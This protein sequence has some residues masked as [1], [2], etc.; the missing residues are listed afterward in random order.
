MDPVNWTKSG[1]G[2][3]EARQGN[4]SLLVTNGFTGPAWAVSLD[5]GEVLR[6]GSASSLQGAML[7]A[8]HAAQALSRELLP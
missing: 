4:I 1:D 3:Y 2:S 7:K 8:K 6:K 5:G